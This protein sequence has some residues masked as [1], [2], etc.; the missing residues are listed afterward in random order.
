MKILYKFLTALIFFTS[1]ISAQNATDYFPSQSGYKWLYR[2]IPLDSLNMERD[3]LVFF[4]SDS[5]A[6]VSNYKGRT[7]NILLSK[8]GPEISLPSQQYTDSLFFSPENSNMFEYSQVGTFVTFLSQLDSVLND[9]TFSFLS[10][11]KSLEDWYS[12]Y[13]FN[14]SV[15]N[16]Y[17]IYSV[18]T[19]INIQS[20]NVPL[21]F[22]YLGKRLNDETIQT[23]IGSFDCKKIVIERSVTA[24]IF[25]ELVSVNDTIWIAPDNWIVKSFIPSSNVD[26]SQ[27]GF[28]AF[29][30]PG[31]K[32]DIQ[33]QVVFVENESEYPDDFVLYQN[34]PNPF[35]PS[36]KINL[37]LTKDNFVK[38][39]IFDVL[40]NKVYT[41]VNEYLKSGDYT[42]NFH[43]N[44]LSSGIYYYTLS[45]GD[46]VI[47]KKMIFLK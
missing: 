20:L 7:A 19:T 12:V 32:M 26:L 33:D 29:Y 18:D 17:T 3:S 37:L 34:Y 15:N 24:F 5:F 41:L 36:T 25:F 31:M 1:F 27:L 28:G 38:L 47:S 43:P 14:Q 40:G 2:S 39:E 44:K 13:R 46:R 11:F 10:F 30:I 6:I 23:Q 21:R 4:R 22:K 45:A 42:Y 9:S 16:Q 8:T 35:N